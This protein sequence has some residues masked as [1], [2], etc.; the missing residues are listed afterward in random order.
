MNKEKTIRKLKL[1]LRITTGVILIGF[2]VIVTMP[3]SIEAGRVPFIVGFI[4]G[5]SWL[6]IFYSI[7][8]DIGSYGENKEEPE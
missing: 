4:S 3:I 2:A 1:Y 6:C 5:M 8:K 7:M